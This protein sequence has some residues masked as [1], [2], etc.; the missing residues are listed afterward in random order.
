MEHTSDSCN[1][2]WYYLH[3]QQRVVFID[4]IIKTS[5][6]HLLSLVEILK[7]DWYGK[8]KQLNMIF[9]WYTYLLFSYTL[10]PIFLRRW[11]FKIKFLEAKLQ[12]MYK[13]KYAQGD[14]SFMWT[15]HFREKKIVV[16]EAKRWS[17]RFVPWFVCPDLKDM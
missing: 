8:W 16:P 2:L 1:F 3:E 14:K 7:Y 13:G 10:L 9:L 17:L 4:K 11:G 5:G 12:G 15:I 6:S